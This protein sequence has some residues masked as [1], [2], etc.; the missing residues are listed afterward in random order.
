MTLTC[1]VNKYLYTNI[2]WIL[3]RQIGNRTINHSISKQRSATT[4]KYSTILTA[5]VH[6]ATRADS[7]VYE[8]RATNTYSGDIVSQSKKIIITGEHLARTHFSRTSKQRRK[9]YATESRG[10]H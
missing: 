2:T 3:R 6:N 9:H 5:T 1:S 7:G 10:A 4:T 8:C